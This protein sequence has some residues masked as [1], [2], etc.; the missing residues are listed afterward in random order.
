MNQLSKHIKK[1]RKPE[2][3]SKNTLNKLDTLHPTSTFAIKIR[4]Q[5]GLLCVSCQSLIQDVNSAQVKTK[6]QTRQP[7]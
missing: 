2:S 7:E 6:W 4:N 1:P 5:M 3:C